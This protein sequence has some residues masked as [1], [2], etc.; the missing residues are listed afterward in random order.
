MDLFHSWFKLDFAAETALVPL[1]ECLPQELA[2]HPVPPC[3]YGCFLGHLADMADFGH[4]F[5][6]I[7]V[8]RSKGEDR[9]APGLMAK[10]HCTHRG[11][12]HLLN[13]SQQ[14]QP[15]MIPLSAVPSRLLAT[16]P[17]LSNLTAGQPQ[18]QLSLQELLVFQDTG[19]LAGSM[20]AHS[21]CPPC[22][23]RSSQRKAAWVA[24][25]V[26]AISWGVSPCIQWTNTC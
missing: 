7:L 11:P 1:V 15:C 16:E 13:G 6:L 10:G 25:L 9:W 17:A 2:P 3:W 12:G 8:R 18:C 20:F 5:A 24:G 21:I 4:G 22:W 19:V 23:C 14:F 26:R